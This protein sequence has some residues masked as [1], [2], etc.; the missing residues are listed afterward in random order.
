MEYVL[1]Q[2]LW[3]CIFLPQ[4]LIYTIGVQELFVEWINIP[5]VPFF[6]LV[7]SSF[8]YRGLQS[9][10]GNTSEQIG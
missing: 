3:C 2:E 6:G 9:H 5:E 4:Y 10:L 7:T 1:F 8:V